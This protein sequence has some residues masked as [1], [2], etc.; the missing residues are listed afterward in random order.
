L[1]P[2][3]ES[4]ANRLAC[5]LFR[6]ADHQLERAEMKHGDR[7]WRSRA[8]AKRPVSEVRFCLMLE[9]ALAVFLV[10]SALRLHEALGPTL[11]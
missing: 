7:F 6:L 10:I 1:V 8:E 9:F 4:I 5:F 11:R 2:Q 3:A